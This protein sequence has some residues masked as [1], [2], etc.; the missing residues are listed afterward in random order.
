MQDY[1]LA[2]ER[3]ITRYSQQADTLAEAARHHFTSPGKRTRSQLLFAAT[4]HIQNIQALVHAAAAIELIHEASIVH[5]DIQ[6]KTNRRR[7]LPTVWRKFGADAALLLGDHLVAAAFRSIA[8]APDIDDIKGTLIVA[9]SE[10]VSRAASGQHLQLTNQTCS[11][12]EAFYVNV[13][14]NKTGALLALPLQFAS[15]FNQQV[16][17]GA[18]AARRCGEQLGL[19]YQILDDLKPYAMPSKLAD[20]EDMQNRVITAPVA[21][22]SMLFPHVDPF[23]TLIKKT[24]M[25]DKAT[26]EC[27][28]W[29]DTAVAN[30]RYETTF[31]DQAVARVVEQFIGQRLSQKLAPTKNAASRY[32]AYSPRVTARVEAV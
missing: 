24:D 18:L 4:P 22:C 8:E 11:D 19:A 21:A 1:Q 29:L 28:R 31:L 30:A 16:A 3:T 23:Q 2:L 13:A 26:L 6:D 25:R 12:V 17:T 14:V 20:D 10:S 9:L 32:S 7:G 27:Q 5:D 15:L